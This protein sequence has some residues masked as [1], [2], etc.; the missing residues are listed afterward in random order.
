MDKVLE[1]RA[2]AVARRIP[3]E[4]LSGDWAYTETV[5][6]AV[7]PPTAVSLEIQ[8]DVE[9]AYGLPGEGANMIH[10]ACT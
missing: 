2:R 8:H 1:L 10:H 4:W 3:E 5:S 6:T 9:A 7:R